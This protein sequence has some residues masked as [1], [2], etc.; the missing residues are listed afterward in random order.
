V[1][2][3]RGQFGSE[4]G[5]AGKA[6]V[7]L[8]TTK[9]RY[10]FIATPLG[11]WPGQGQPITREALRA[12]IP[13]SAVRHVVSRD[14]GTHHIELEVERPSHPA[15]MT[16]IEG[17]IARL[18]LDVAEAEIAE[19]I[20]NELAGA[21]VGG[22]G[23]ALGG[24]ATEN[25]LAFVLLTGLGTLGGTVVGSLIETVVARYEAGRDPYRGWTVTRV[26]LSPALDP[27]W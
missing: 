26:D 15:A 17:A 11:G 12:L 4:Q 10:A 18:G 16:E 5:T 9:K 27:A 23:G 25:P 20:T 19:L 6:E 7:A 2:G 3:P 1:A 14:D 24:V 22:G 8:V 13:G 21:V